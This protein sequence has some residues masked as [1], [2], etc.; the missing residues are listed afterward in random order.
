MDPN[1]IRIL[2][3][4]RMFIGDIP[5]FFLVEVIVRMFILF[6]LIIVS[7]RLIG[8]RMASSLNRNDLA[9]LVAIAAAVGIPMQEPSRGL[10]PAVVIAMTIVGFIKL[11]NHIIAESDKFEVAAQG[12]VGILVTDGIIQ[13]KNLYK[14]SIS[15]QRLFAHLRNAQVENLGQVQ[16]LY[17]ESSGTYTVLLFKTPH[18]GLS[19]IPVWDK[20]F[21]E[22]RK[23]SPE[24]Y[25]CTNCG[26]LNAQKKSKH[27]P[28]CNE[29]NWVN[30]V[31]I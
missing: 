12:D 27:C 16:R 29:S 2:D 31:N 15:R 21:T 17:L 1:T 9:A 7:M 6:M 14:G 10:L 20:D 23:I 26:W 18:E 4:H 25:A 5:I 28:V 30:A 13:L 3:P 19:I 24:N 11:L 8:Q 22:P